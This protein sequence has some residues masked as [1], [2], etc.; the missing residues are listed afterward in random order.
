MK[1]A[2]L[3][4]SDQPCISRGAVLQ[5]AVETC[6]AGTGWKYNV[7]TFGVCDVFRIINLFFEHASLNAHSSGKSRELFVGQPSILIRS[8]YIVRHLFRDGLKLKWPEGF[9]TVSYME[10]YYLNYIWLAPTPSLGS[11]AELNGE[12][13]QRRKPV[14]QSLKIRCRLQNRLPSVQSSIHSAPL[15]S[16]QSST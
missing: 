9:N 3:W 13:R 8:I 16:L 11:G 7:S 6:R 12:K 1:G 14:L 5:Y 10:I 2:R 4:G 15:P